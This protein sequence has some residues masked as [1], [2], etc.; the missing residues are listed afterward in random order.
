[1]IDVN[2]TLNKI[3]NDLKK[4]NLAATHLGL[5]GGLMSLSLF[6]FYYSRFIS[7]ETQEDFASEILN[8][9]VEKMADNIIPSNYGFGLAGIG[10]CIE[11]LSKEKFLEIDSGDTFEELEKMIFTD[12]MRN[13]ILDYSFQTGIIGLCNYFIINQSNKTEE[14]VKITLD[15]LCSGFA[16]PNFPKHPV[17]T[18]FL[19]PSEVLQDIK[20][21]LCKVEKLNI[22]HGQIALLKRYIENFEKKHITL[23]SNCFEYFKVQYLRRTIGFKNKPL[24]KDTFDIYV[25]HLSDKVMFGLTLM[26][27]KKPDLPN[28]WKIL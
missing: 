26:Y 15:R 13:L 19:M 22:H 27:H 12:I 9:I 23:Q 14:A 24:L 21:F 17:E 11:F 5:N 6:F 1:M 7:D 25:A 10:S 3:V 28:I 8:I 2:E 20:L 16:I 18:V 4:S